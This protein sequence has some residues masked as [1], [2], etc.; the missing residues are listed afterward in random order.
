[1]LLFIKQHQ[2]ELG[3]IQHNKLTL[4]KFL[5]VTVLEQLHRCFCVVAVVVFPET[6]KSK[7]YFVIIQRPLLNQNKERYSGLKTRLSLKRDFK[8]TLK[9]H[10]PLTF[11]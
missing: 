1:M 2:N 9:F 5:S 10:G 8:A 3:D 7:T 6:Y 4:L 11:L